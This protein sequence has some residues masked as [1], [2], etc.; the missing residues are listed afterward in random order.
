MTAFR[1]LVLTGCRLS[2]IQTLRWDY[3]DDLYIRLPD[4]KTGARKIPIGTAVRSELQRLRRAP[5]NPYVIVGTRPGQHLTDL[6]HPWRRIRER[7]GLS[8]VRIHDLRHTY[9]SNA[10][11]AGLSLEMVGKL[12]GHTQFQTTMRYAHIAD[13]PVREA[14][15]KVASGRTAQ[16]RRSD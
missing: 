9:A 12:L 14:A 3:I 16:G 8:D 1:L 2:E 11:T 5:D 7:A 6:Q 10:L 13:N 4:S 15:S